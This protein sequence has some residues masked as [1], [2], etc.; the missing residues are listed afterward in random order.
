MYYDNFKKIGWSFRSLVVL[1]VSMEEEW[2]VEEEVS[3]E[4]EWV[5]E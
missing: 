4:E 1:E 5:V 2:V 3:M